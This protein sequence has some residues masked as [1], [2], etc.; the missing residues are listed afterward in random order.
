MRIPPYYRRPSW[1]RFISGMAV[2]GAISWCIFLY[3]YG[4]FQEDNA[5]LIRKQQKDIA[6][7]KDDVKIWQQDYA[8]LNNKNLGKITIEKINIRITNW[9]KYKLDQFSVFQTEEAVRDD[10][11]IVLAKDLETVA[12]SKDMLKKIIENKPYELNEKR[13]R[14][15][16]KEMVIY[17]TLTIQLEME[18][19]E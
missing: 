12:K 7:L 4:V 19:A 5:K 1:Q 10:I 18:F 9:E 15:K 16:V 6:E 11:K 8:E 14:L 2:G 3:I 17:T 13:Y